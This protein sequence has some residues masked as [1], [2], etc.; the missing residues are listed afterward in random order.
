MNEEVQAH[1][2][3][4]FVVRHLGRDHSSFEWCTVGVNFP[5]HLKIENAL[6]TLQP[7]THIL[8]ELLEVADERLLTDGALHLIRR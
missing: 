3:I 6:T 8:A 2:E 1:R 4:P 5:H 7:Q